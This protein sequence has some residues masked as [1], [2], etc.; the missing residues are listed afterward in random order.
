MLQLVIRGYIGLHLS[1]FSFQKIRTET[2]EEFFIKS[3]VKFQLAV[4]NWADRQ[5]NQSIEY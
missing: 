5:K 3:C 1:Y 4:V 2:S